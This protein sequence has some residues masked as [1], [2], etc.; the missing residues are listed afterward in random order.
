MLQRGDVNNM[1]NKLN[2]FSSLLQMLCGVLAVLTYIRFG[3]GELT[4]KWIGTL[5]LA[6]MFFILGVSGLKDYMSKK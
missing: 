5:V 1:K 6:V 4:V 2:L 3:I